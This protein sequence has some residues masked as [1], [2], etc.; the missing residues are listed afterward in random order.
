MLENL[1]VAGVLALSGG[2]ILRRLFR[3][4]MAGK[5]KAPACNSCSSGTCGSV[6]SSAA[7]STVKVEQGE[8]P[9]RMS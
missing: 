2:Y 7:K 4:S 5:N 1:F 9:L 8:T 3:M 6:T